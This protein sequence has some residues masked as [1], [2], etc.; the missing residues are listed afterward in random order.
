M[1]GCARCWLLCMGFS[2]CGEWGL[3]LVA[4]CG[5]LIAVASPVAGHRLCSAGLVALKHV[6]YSRTRDRTYVP[7]IGR[8]NLN[9]WAT[10]EVPLHSILS[11]HYLTG[12]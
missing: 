11:S 7:C 1:F 2:S 12:I 8:Q 9:H 4:L 6:E 3:L 10:M 5:L